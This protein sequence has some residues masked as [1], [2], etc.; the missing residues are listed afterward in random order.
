MRKKLCFLLPNIDE[1]KNLVNELLIANIDDYHIHVIAKDDI[2]LDGLPEASINLKPNFIHSMETGM[3]IG[4]LLGLLSAIVFIYTLQFNSIMSLVAL[5]FTITGAA[6]GIWISGII[7]K[8]LNDFR[9]KIFKPDINAGKI[10]VIADVPADKI[11]SVNDTIK[12][13][14][15]INLCDPNDTM[16]AY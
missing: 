10:L 9:L 6:T 13:H 2:N 4:G 1:T 8:F 16:P 15:Q 14:T 7:A 11:K 12:I 3:F 5:V